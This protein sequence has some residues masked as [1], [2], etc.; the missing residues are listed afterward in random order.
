MLWSLTLTKIDKFDM[1]CERLK[2]K[3]C[4]LHVIVSD[5]CVTPWALLARLLCPWDFPDKNTGGGCHFLLQRSS[6]PRD[7]THISCISCIGRQLFYKLHHVK[8]SKEVR[9]IEMCFY[10]VGV[11]FHSILSQS[12]ILGN[13]IPNYWDLGT[14][15]GTIKCRLAAFI[16]DAGII[17]QGILMFRC[18][19]PLQ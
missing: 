10:W 16:F 18:L 2:I 3:I 1:W 4:N 7:W 9:K 13:P 14:M 19:V 11:V 6:W 5:F 12:R 17:L 8:S 15:C